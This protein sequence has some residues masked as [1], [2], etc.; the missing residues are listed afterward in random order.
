MKSVAPESRMSYWWV[1]ALLAWL[2]FILGLALRDRLPEWASIASGLGLSLGL[3]FATLYKLILWSCYITQ[4]FGNDNAGC[5]AALAGWL[6]PAV[7]L[8][9]ASGWRAGVIYF[10]CFAVSWAMVI[11]SSAQSRAS[12]PHFA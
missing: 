10:I 11:Y 4:S 12:C 6:I 8:G 2:A 3:L 5:I 1:L 7:L 9:F